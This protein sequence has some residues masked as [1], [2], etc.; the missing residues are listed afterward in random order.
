MHTATASSARRPG[1]RSL[2]DPA[3]AGIGSD[4]VVVS[5]VR[6]AVGTY[7]GGL[8]D[9]PAHVLGATVIRTA[10]ERARLAPDEVAEVVMGQVG[11]IG[12][13]AYNARR[14]SM[15]AG[16]PPST[17]AMNVNRLCGSGLQAISS[18]A[19]EI[20]LGEAGIV[21]AGGNESMTRQPFLDFATRVGGGALGDRTL[22]DGTLSLLT[23][24]L[25]GYPM[26]RPPSESP[27]ASA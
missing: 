27:S 18:A 9:V 15:A 6:T 24:P 26:G 17:T 16:L 4:V 22:V 25:G 3:H 2:P 7:L 23:D 8:R 5:A 19:Q 12:A 21:V 14:C 11:Q 10:V 1:G 20:R 13:D